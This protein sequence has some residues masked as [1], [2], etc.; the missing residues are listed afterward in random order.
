LGYEPSHDVRAGLREAVG[1][2]VKHLA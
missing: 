2:Y 1:W